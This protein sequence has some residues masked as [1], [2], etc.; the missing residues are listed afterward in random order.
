MKKLLISE[1]NAII[2]EIEPL[3]DDN[4]VLSSSECPGEEGNAHI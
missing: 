3:D 1:G 4:F 2:E